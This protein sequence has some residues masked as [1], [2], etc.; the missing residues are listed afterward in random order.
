[1]SLDKYRLLVLIKLSLV[2]QCS[3]TVLFRS[4]LDLWIRLNFSSGTIVIGAVY[5]QWGSREKEDLVV[6]HEHASSVAS[7][8]TR[9]AI[10]GDLNLDASRKNDPTYY[11]FS[12]SRCS[13]SMLNL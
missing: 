9:T 4:G 7:S 5:R 13:W 1:M 12:L 10:L 6:F 8:H 2:S 3:P 11:R